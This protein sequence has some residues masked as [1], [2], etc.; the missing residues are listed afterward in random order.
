V[1]IKSEYRSDNISS[2]FANLLKSELLPP[3]EGFQYSNTPLFQPV[4]PK[5]RL[6]VTKA[7]TPWQFIYG[8]A[9]LLYPDS[10]DQALNIGIDYAGI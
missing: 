6:C 10:D 5:S 9:N 4:P 3:N 8:K 7:D 1:G 2:I